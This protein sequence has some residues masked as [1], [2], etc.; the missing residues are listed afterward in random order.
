MRLGDASLQVYGV[1]I[2][3]QISSPTD[4]E[5]ACGLNGDGAA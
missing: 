2:E 5:R 3:V 1:S 4:V